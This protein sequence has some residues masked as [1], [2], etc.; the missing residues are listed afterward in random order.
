[1]GQASTRDAIKLALDTR[2]TP[3]IAVTGAWGV[4]KTYLWNELSKELKDQKL[5]TPIYI[6]ALSYEDVSSIKSAVTSLL[7]S[8]VVPE[9]KWALAGD[10]LASIFKSLRHL[11]PDSFKIDVSELYPLL[12]SIKEKLPNNIVLVIDDIERSEGID[13]SIFMGFMNYL[14]ENVGLKVVLILNQSKLEGKSKR[15]WNNLREKFISREVELVMTC[16]ESVGIGLKE[17]DGRISDAI[18][19]H[20]KKLNINNI[21]IMHHISRVFDSLSHDIDL[22]NKS[23][24]DLLSFSIVLLTSL[25]FNCLEGWPT[26]KEV[27]DYDEYVDRADEGQED[28]K[29]EYKKYGCIYPDDFEKEILLPFLKTGHLNKVAFKQYIEDVSYR[30][31]NN[32]VRAGIRD[33]VDK[34][35]WDVRYK[36]IE[37]LNQLLVFK[38][39]AEFISA[40]DITVLHKMAVKYKMVTSVD[41]VDEWLRKNSLK[42]SEMEMSRHDFMDFYGDVHGKINQLYRKRYKELYPDLTLEQCIIYRASSSGSSDWNDIPIKNANSDDFRKLLIYGDVDLQRSIYKF[43][44]PIYQGNYLGSGW[45]IRHK[46]CLKLQMIW[47]LLILMSE[48]RKCGWKKSVTGSN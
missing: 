20:I 15:A 33:F 19:P 23:C 47:P 6:S 16:D 37:I 30:I 40:A 25:H 42:I 12:P 45:R 48:L 14:I 10:K 21:R 26:I 22:N 3:V 9:G 46:W 1:M 29:E 5:I 35:Y 39:Q 2:N 8:T 41:L 11:I 4:G 38:S 36:K 18:S 27:L 44:K 32:A 7:L 31:N 24:L 34:V 43:F 17:L 13:I 28:W